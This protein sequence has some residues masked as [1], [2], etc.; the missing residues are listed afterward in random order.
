MSTPSSKKNF[1]QEPIETTRHVR[2]SLAQGNIIPSRN[3]SGAFKKGLMRT[4]N[5]VEIH[6]TGR[7]ENPVT[8]LPG[9][10]PVLPRIVTRVGKN[11]LVVRAIIDNIQRLSL[12]PPLGGQAV[13]SV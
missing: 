7:P 2:I 13:I 9:D 1:A 3:S 4:N 12:A 10:A 11:E 5:L 8:S 6:R